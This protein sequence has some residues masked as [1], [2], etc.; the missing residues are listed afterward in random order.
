MADLFKFIPLRFLVTSGLVISELLVALSIVALLIYALLP[1]TYDMIDVNVDLSV[2][3]DIKRQIHIIKDKI[4]NLKDDIHRPIEETKRQLAKLANT[5]RL[6]VPSLN[7]LPD[8]L[9]YADLSCNFGVHDL[10]GINNIPGIPNVNADPCK[11]I[12]TPLNE[13]YYILY[14][15]LQQVED[16]INDALMIVPNE[17]KKML[18]EL[19]TQV[20]SIMEQI[21]NQWMPLIRTLTNIRDKIMRVVELVMNEG[22]NIILGIIIYLLKMYF[23]YVIIGIIG[24]SIAAISVVGAY[25][26]LLMFMYNINSIPVNMI[27]GLSGL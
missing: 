4:S 17:F 12:M 8:D 14:Q 24:L 21:K 26:S 18:Q 23:L 15:A 5:L 6:D 20:V 25:I 27:L 11:I 13:G 10:P 19:K 22:Y 16:E 3:D 2:I 7:M 9:P 1:R